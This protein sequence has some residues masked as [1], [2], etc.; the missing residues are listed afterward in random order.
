MADAHVWGNGNREQQY[1]AA[2]QEFVAWAKVHKIPHSQPSI[3]TTNPC[4]SYPNFQC[5]AYNGRVVLAWMA[6]KAVQNVNSYHDEQLASALRWHL[7]NWFNLSERSPQF[8]T[9]AYQEVAY[10]TCKH[11]SPTASRDITACAGG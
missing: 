2:Y 10:W 5:K 6:G 1:K 3:S 11:R 7:A 8:L 4:G 9:E